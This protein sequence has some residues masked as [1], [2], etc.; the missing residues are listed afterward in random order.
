MK[1]KNQILHPEATFV[2]QTET[3]RLCPEDISSPV[4]TFLTQMQSRASIYSGDTVTTPV[5]FADPI[6]GHAR[7]QGL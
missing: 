1:K 3:W 5:P 4:P 6:P 2:L 7:S